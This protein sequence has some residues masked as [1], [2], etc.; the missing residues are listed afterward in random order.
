MNASERNRVDAFRQ[1]K[2]QIRGSTEDLVVGLD[3]SKPYCCKNSAYA[4]LKHQAA[5]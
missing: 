4:P 5:R 1:F 3:I 2:K